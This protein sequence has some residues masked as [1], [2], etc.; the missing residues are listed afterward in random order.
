[1]NS[2][3]TV[4]F[5]TELFKAHG[6][7]TSVHDDWV[8][9][10]SSVHAIRATWHPRAD[11]GRLN[12]HVHGGGDVVIEEAFAG[13]G[14]GEIGLND[15]LANFA[16]NSFH[17]LLAAFWNVNDPC[18]VVTESW[19]INGNRYAAYIGNL[20]TRAFEGV[21]PCVPQSLFPGIERAIKAEH[22]GG[23]LHWFRFFFANLAG[24]YTLESL[25]DNEDWDSGVAMLRQM[26]WEPSPGYYSVRLFM[27]LRKMPGEPA[28]KG[29]LLSRLRKLF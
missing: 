1:M 4:S 22:L 14:A 24:E 27:V 19:A 16:R 17:V 21:E 3:I 28:R 25:L 7:Q 20:G 11:S 2:G 13:I 6:I 23:E 18:Q 26:P 15:G 12:V 29:S 5:L 10:E 9:P 8:V